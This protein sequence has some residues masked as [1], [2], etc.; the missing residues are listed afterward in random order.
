MNSAYKKEVIQHLTSQSNLHFIFFTNSSNATN[1]TPFIG[2]RS[3]FIN[4]TEIKFSNK[5]DWLK[6]TITSNI[7]MNT[8]EQI[9]QIY[10]IFKGATI[11]RILAITSVQ[12]LSCF[13]CIY[14]Q[15]RSAILF[16]SL[17]I[18]NKNTDSQPKMAQTVEHANAARNVPRL[19]PRTVHLLFL[20]KI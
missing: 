20:I 15:V 12:K 3:Y 6:Y 9:D 7:I 10:L 16:Y 13:F 4:G 11:L 18:L 17:D 1:R 14:I 2:V 5:I 8:S 19:E